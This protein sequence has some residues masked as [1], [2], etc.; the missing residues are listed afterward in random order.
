MTP[1]LSRR[2]RIPKLLTR[3]ARTILLLTLL[4]SGIFYA[5]WHYRNALAYYFS[6]R[7]DDFSEEQKIHALRNF[8]VLSRHPGL[9]VGFDVSQYQGE[10][11]WA[12]ADSIDNRFALD[13]VFIRATAGKDAVDEKFYH[14][15]IL[16]S[17]TR[18]LR[19]AY[20]YY[21]PNENSVEQAQNFIA[22]VKLKK[23][24]LPPVLDIEQIP[25]EQSM[26][27]LKAGLKR[28]LRIVERHYGMKPI[29][30][31][32]ESFYHDFLREDFGR[33][34]FWIAN[35]NFFVESI[36]DEWMMWQFSENATIPGIEGPVDAN[37][38]N[39]SLDELEELSRR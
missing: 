35:Y 23:G 1:Y 6:Y 5:A 38:F 14:N 8:Q 24:D 27:S 22:T 12:L 15:W 36:D 39:G 26:D 7:T 32:G 10:I 31:T 13:F 21:R 29:I 17:K 33:Y 25:R 20:H 11:N 4:L 37:I 30:Y 28:W 19:G 16:S 34:D 9:S 18:L 3:K 2:R